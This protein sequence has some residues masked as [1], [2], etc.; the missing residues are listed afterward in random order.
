MADTREITV[1]QGVRGGAIAISGSRGSLV[2]E[3]FADIVEFS[4]MMAK[5]EKAVPKIFRGNPGACMAVTIQANEWGFSPFAVARMAYEV[6]D[7]IAYMSQLIHAVVEKR[8]PLKS[9]LKVEYTGEGVERQATIIGHFISEVDPVSYTS[10]KIKDIRVKNSPLWTGDPDQQLFYYASRAWA[11]RYCPEVILGVYAEDELPNRP[12]HIGADNAKDVTPAAEEPL[13][14][15]LSLR[16]AAQA[17]FDPSGI[18]ATMDE[19]SGRAAPDAPAAQDAPG[20]APEGQA[21]AEGSP[22]PAEDAHS[23]VSP[24]P[25]AADHSPKGVDESPA[26]HQE[27][28]A[29]K[30]VAD[31][32]PPSTPA[33]SEASTVSS[34]VPPDQELS[35]QSS[36]APEAAAEGATTASPVVAEP[37][38]SAPAPDAAPAAWTAPPKPINEREYSA[39]VRQSLKNPALDAESLVRAWWTSTEERKIRKGLVNLTTDLL[40]EA[41]EIVAARI[42]MINEEIGD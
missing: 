39:Y 26:V 16:A 3:K 15:R 1:E 9:R 5:S 27:G 31:V 23:P 38:A 28:E 36:P 20:V 21:A 40:D 29:A 22:P 17:G 10:P 13:L 7:Q 2:F 11:R 32:M 35:A 12:Q 14:H 25:A 18:A 8:A 19:V 6:S 24:S 34:S 37:Q 42:R 30:E 4:M 33:A 41:K